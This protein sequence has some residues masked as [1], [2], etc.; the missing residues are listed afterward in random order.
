MSL[1]V[2]AWALRE[3]NNQPPT[4]SPM[5]S[6]VAPVTASHRK[7]F[8]R[9]STRLSLMPRLSTRLG[10]SFQ[11]LQIRAN[12]GS[13]LVTKLLV[14]LQRLVDY[15]ALAP[16]EVVRINS[17]QRG[18]HSIQN[19]V[20][21]DRSTFAREGNPPVAISYSTAPKEEQVPSV[22]LVLRHAPAQETCKR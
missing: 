7:I 1:S 12:F 17:R 13:G 6:T 18:R 9:A 19:L 16:A 11:S 15:C 2:S 10:I 4:A 22:H 20:M 21:D 5:T 3:K 8:R 14:F